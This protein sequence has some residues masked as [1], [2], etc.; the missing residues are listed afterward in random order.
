MTGGHDPRARAPLVAARVAPIVWRANRA[1]LV[2]MVLCVACAAR[3]PAVPPSAPPVL[4]SAAALEA[5]LANRRQ[6]LRTLRALARVRY[7]DADGSNSSRQAVIAA[8]PDRLR[9]EVL[10]VFGSPF[11]LAVNDGALVAYARQENTVYRGHASAENLWRYV[12]LGLPIDEL[13]DIVLA[14]PRLR[15]ARQAEVAFDVGL[16]AVRLT[17]D[18]PRGVQVVWFSETLPIAAEQRGPEGGTMWR[19]TFG[20]YEDRGG[21]KVASRLRLELPGRG[22]SVEMELEDIDVNPTVDEKIFA[23]QTPPGSRVVDLDPIVN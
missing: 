2:A 15:A 4:P 14:T 13:I 21:M 12:R 19:A 1:L 17:A 22:R 23:V 9:I 16:G 11:V 10:S 3:R 18:S 5:A 8:R 6:G 20:G 7:R